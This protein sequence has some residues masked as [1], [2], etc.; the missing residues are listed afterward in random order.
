MTS[1]STF[2]DRP[3]PEATFEPQIGETSDPTASLPKRPFPTFDATYL[4]H[5]KGHGAHEVLVIIKPQALRQVHQHA[6]SNM[7]SELGGF[8][9]GHAF[10]NEGRHH[11]LIETA[12]P[13]LS[14]DHGPV[15]FTFGADS[16][17]E[18]HRRKDALFPDL[19]IIG[20]YHT[21][22]GLGVF[23]SSD[24]V[25]VHSAGFVMPWHVGLVVD[26]VRNEASF[27]GWVEGDLACL[28]GYYEQS[29]ST[30]A[31][32]TAP[33]HYTHSSVHNFINHEL[34]PL[35]GSL[36][37]QSSQSPLISTSE[38][39][40]LAAVTGVLLFFFVAGWIAL[41][42]RQVAQLQQ[43]ILSQADANPALIQESCPDPRLRIVSPQSETAVAQ[44]ERLQLLGTA[45][46]PTASR[47]EVWVRPA[48]SGSAW[49][50]I[51]INRWDKTLGT[52][53]TWNTID[54]APGL[55]DV[56]ITA[57]DR[58]NSLLPGLPPC[59]IQVTITE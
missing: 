33:W 10:Q 7:R 12:L 6:I 24:D 26:P 21:H 29:G 53:A 3:D 59:Q 15:H 44:G 11:I 28:S 48:D 27:F 8:L 14:D 52:L 31:A 51:G 9:L 34:P 35:P 5:G 45:D 55:Y 37:S 56:G 43:V 49:Q 23:Y 46:L 30:T 58:T 42:E 1:A 18:C 41:L 54:V 25:I 39:G 38:W 20:W 50:R 4:Q 19:R 22:P 36:V 2:S 40:M 32:S 16:W 17:S 57:V 13:A 47:Y